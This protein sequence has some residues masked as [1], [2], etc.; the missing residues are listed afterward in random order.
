MICY[1]WDRA[2]EKDN[3]DVSGI[4]G[5][6][7][8]ELLSI[9][10]CRSV[11]HIIKKGIFKEYI[12]VYEETASLKGK[13]NF[14]DSLKRNSFRNG[15]G[16]CEFDEFSDDVIY[17][18]IIKSTLYNIL[19]SKSINKTIKDEVMKIYHYFSGISNIKLSKRCFDK[20][21][22]YKNNNHYKLSL[23]ICKLIYD[24]MIVDENSGNIKFKEFY[25]EDKEMAYIFENFVRNFYN[26]HLKDS[27]VYRENIKWHAVGEELSLL[28]IMQTDITIKSSEN[29]I[30]MDTKYYR[31]TL[32]R[33][34]QSEK[35]HSNNMYQMFA[36]LKN[37]E[38]KG[39]I[40]KNS[41]GI[42]LL[43]ISL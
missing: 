29:I 31:N 13:I 2:R 7:L 36:Y 1:V 15:R 12:K 41:T 25:R 28:P 3:V 23:N 38:A 21:R 22:I 35:Y 37:A 43:N 39:D 8:Y 33:N 42:L 19:K 34:M 17:N 14:N 9:V 6:N 27:K 40:Y 16:F 20:V 24:N 11:S 18:Q 32:A 10:L 26:T 4:K 30:I 5:D